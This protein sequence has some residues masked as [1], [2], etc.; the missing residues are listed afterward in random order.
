M[1]ITGTCGTGARPGVGA[2]VTGVAMGIGVMLAIGF[3]S[4]IVEGWTLMLGAGGGPAVAEAA[5]TA[6]LWC[7]K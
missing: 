6:V 3:E 2:G 1:A 7:M 5:A 4:G